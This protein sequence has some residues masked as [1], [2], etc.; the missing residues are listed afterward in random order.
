MMEG[1]IVQDGF[2][3][4]S[5]LLRN[6]YCGLISFTLLRV[7]TFLYKLEYKYEYFKYKYYIIKVL[8]LNSI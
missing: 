3:Q 5:R 2:C 1:N 8:I 7:N 6:E 4:T